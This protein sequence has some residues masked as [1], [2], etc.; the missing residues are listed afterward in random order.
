[1]KKTNI[2][3]ALV[4]SISTFTA[5][6]ASPLTVTVNAI[7]ADGVGKPIGTIR[8]EDGKQGLVLTVALRGLAPGDHGFHVHENPNC[9]PKEKDG[10]PVAGLAAGSHYDPAKTG[11]HAGPSAPGHLG[12]LPT[13]SA[14]ANGNANGRLIAP[15]L[16]LADLKGRSI[17]VH[18][19][20]DNYA[21]N[22]KPLG[23]GGARIACGAVS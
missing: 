21:D 2:A 5:L 11:K 3:T 8:A 9:G 16:K 20:G 19:G 13:L 4:F 6:A 17:V 10:K 14:D 12:D 18:E 15:R 1:M 22:P 23:G 7:N